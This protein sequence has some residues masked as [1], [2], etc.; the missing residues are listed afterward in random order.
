MCATTDSLTCN[1]TSTPN[2]YPDCDGDG[3][4]D[5]T[6]TPI[7]SC[8]MPTQA[9]TCGSVANAMGSP[10]WVMGV[11][12]ADADCCDVDGNANHNQTAFF[13]TPDACGGSLPFDY[14]CDGV[15]EMQS[16]GPTDCL[17]NFSCVPSG[18]SCVEGNTLPADCGGEPTIFGTAACGK[19]YG[20]SSDFCE[21]SG[22]SPTT[23]TGGSTGGAAGTQACH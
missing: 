13:T 5:L 18:T 11:T 8:T 21:V 16:N 10:T 17:A 12:S 3:E 22:T 2:W 14:N 1:I 6:Q 20:F 19:T 4:G 7:A 23:C 15:Q 9:P